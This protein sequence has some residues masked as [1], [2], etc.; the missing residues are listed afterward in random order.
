M[1]GLYGSLGVSGGQPRR[2]QPR[3]DTQIQIAQPQ[4][5]LSLLFVFVNFCLSRVARSKTPKHAKIQAKNRQLTFFPIKNSHFGA[6]LAKTGITGGQQSAAVH[7]IPGFF[8][9]LLFGH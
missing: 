3:N 1:L 6:S 2:P 4:L 7:V 9:K 8:F 5:F